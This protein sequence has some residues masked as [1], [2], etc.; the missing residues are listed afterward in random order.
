M[1][2][3]TFLYNNG[4]PIEVSQETYP[5]LQQVELGEVFEIN[6]NTNTKPECAETLQKAK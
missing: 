3:E 4:L 6:F 1:S 5:T 2:T